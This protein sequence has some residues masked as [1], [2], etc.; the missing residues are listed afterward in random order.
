M[1]WIAVLIVV[2]V[3]AVA[4]HF[5]TDSRDGRDWAASDVPGRRVRDMVSGCC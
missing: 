5:G 1:G 4:W 3:F 2:A